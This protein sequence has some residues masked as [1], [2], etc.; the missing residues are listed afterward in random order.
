[1]LRYDMKNLNFKKA[2]DEQGKGAQSPQFVAFGRL[3]DIID[4]YW[5]GHRPVAKY[6][7]IDSIVVVVKDIF[8]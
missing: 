4:N 3:A 8:T 7:L 2:E 6:L 5:I 1:M